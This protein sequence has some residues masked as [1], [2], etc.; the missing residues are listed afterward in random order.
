MPPKL[1]P[2]PNLHPIGTSSDC[3]LFLLKFSELLQNIFGRCYF[4]FQLSPG[5]RRYFLQCTGAEW[6]KEKLIVQENNSHDQPLFPGKL[7]IHTKSYVFCNIGRPRRLET[8]LW[9]IIIRDTQPGGLNPLK[10]HPIIKDN[11]IT[12]RYNPQVL[13]PVLRAN[14]GRKESTCLSAEPPPLCAQGRALWGKH[15]CTTSLY[16]AM[17]CCPPHDMTAHNARAQCIY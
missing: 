1:Q 2:S 4:A 14:S 6:P 11:K 10:L 8:L 15:F 9:P 12:V 7:I 5:V 17:T 16:H 3:S 13:Y